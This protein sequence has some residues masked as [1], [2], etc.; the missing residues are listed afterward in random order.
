MAFQSN[1]NGNNN[2]NW[3]AQAFLNF[4]LPKANGEG[5]HKIGAI[6]LKDARK[7]EANLIKRLSEDPEA[8]KKML[9]MLQIDFQLVDGPQAAPS[10]LP[11]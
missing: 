3:K 10:Q 5:R 7:Y 6:P 4:Y 9:T 8:I 1:N 11:F 2:D